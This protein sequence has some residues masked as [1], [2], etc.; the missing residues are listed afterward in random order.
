MDSHDAKP[1]ATEPQLAPAQVTVRQGGRTFHVD[2]QRGET[3]LETM[4]RAGV[5]APSLCEQGLCGTC[6][7]RRVKGDV[8]LRENHVLSD[9]DLA[10]G[11]TLACQ[12]VPSSAVCEIE[13]L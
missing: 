5:L 13:V 12:G 11:Y 9:Q 10:E 6:I 1:P 3:L 8:A 2:Y 4:R 7:V